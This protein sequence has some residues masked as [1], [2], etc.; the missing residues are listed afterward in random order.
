MVN[1]NNTNLTSEKEVKTDSS[2]SGAQ[3]SSIQPKEE[4]MG[5]KELYEQSLNQLQYGDIAGVKL[6]R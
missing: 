6:S 5:F 1:N 2:I 3:N 4:D